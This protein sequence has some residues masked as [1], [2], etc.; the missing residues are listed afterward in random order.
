MAKVQ[1][2]C[3]EIF[4]AH[5]F[6]WK[7]KGFEGP[8]SSVWGKR[9]TQCKS[10]RKQYKAKLYRKKKNLIRELEKFQITHVGQPDPVAFLTP[11]SI[12][13]EDA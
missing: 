2:K 3:H 8:F 11:F 13:L 9:H 10:C 5:H 4:L 7:V 1:S 6:E 12:L